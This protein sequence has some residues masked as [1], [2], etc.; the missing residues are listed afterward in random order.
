MKRF[1]SRLIWVFVAFLAAGSVWAFIPGL[2]KVR[3]CPNCNAHVLEET[4]T[5]GNTIGAAFRTDGKMVAIMLP[6]R[7]RLVR[8]PTCGK[9]FWFNQA[10]TIASGHRWD[11]EIKKLKPLDPELPSETEYL[12]MLADSTLDDKQRL[13]VRHRAWWAANDTI[14]ARKD[15]AA[16]FSE[17]QTVNLQTLVT[18]ISVDTPEGRIEKAEILR[19]LERYGDC[20]AL[21]S[22]PFES[23]RLSR[24]A[25][26]IK[27]LASRKLR[28]ATWITFEQKP[29][30]VDGA[31][32][33]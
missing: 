16:G 24:V 19:E 14:M 7:P 27:N 12:E 33:K 26:F 31:N 1:R 10:K 6:D 22:E 3:V 17:A 25:A 13:Y 8:C 29:D 28:Q 9:P 2:S 23:K 15:T 20:I 32:D 21:L 4:T 18:V 5:S 11:D 30:T